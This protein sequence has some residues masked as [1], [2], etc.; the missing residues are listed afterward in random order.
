MEYY[1]I[2]DLLNEIDHLLDDARSNIIY[3]EDSLSWRQYNIDM[4]GNMVNGERGYLPR[5]TVTS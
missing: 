2:F 4:N 1:S 5:R 3:L